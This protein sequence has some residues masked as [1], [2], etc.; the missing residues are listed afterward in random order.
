MKPTWEGW[1]EVYAAQNA[2]VKSHSD[3]LYR[4]R[5]DGDDL[6]WEEPFHDIPWDHCA[7]EVMA[8][9]ELT[10]TDK[11]TASTRFLWEPVSEESTTWREVDY[12]N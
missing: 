7:Q 10:T 12:P 8:D 5:W 1:P 9:A 4:G 11:I 6:T 2:D 3:C